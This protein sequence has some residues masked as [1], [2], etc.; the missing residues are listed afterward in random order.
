MLYYT[1]IEVSSKQGSIVSRQELQKFA[2]YMLMIYQDLLTHWYSG[3]S[4]IQ[5]KDMLMSVWEKI[6]LKNR[7]NVTWFHYASPRLKNDVK[8]LLHEKFIELMLTWQGQISIADKR[9]QNWFDKNKAELKK[10]ISNLLLSN[11]DI[12]QKLLKEYQVCN[13][14][15]STTTIESFLTPY[16]AK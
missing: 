10:F 9:L 16:Y 4:A 7:P 2:G 1:F 3:D 12:Y 8:E 6:F 15:H 14:S 11:N 13:A 5:I